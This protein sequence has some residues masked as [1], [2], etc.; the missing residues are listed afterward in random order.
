MPRQD[1]IKEVDFFYTGA[2]HKLFYT[3]SDARQTTRTKT[4]A[5]KMIKFSKNSSDVAGVEGVDRPIL[6]QPIGSAE[7]PVGSTTH[8]RTVLAQSVR[9]GEVLAQPVLSN[10][11][12]TRKSDSSSSKQDVADSSVYARKTNTVRGVAGQPRSLDMRR[13]NKPQ[14]SN[15]PRNTTRGLRSQTAQETRRQNAASKEIKRDG[16]T[17]SMQ[18]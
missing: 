16:F 11:T 3:H 6:V 5:S 13:P 9:P 4:K 12:P 1:V 2:E 14:V 18:N 10:S 8:T 15:K 7:P 17:G